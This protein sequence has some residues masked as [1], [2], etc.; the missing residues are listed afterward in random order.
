MLSRNLYIIDGN[1]TAEL[2]K[3]FEENV[4]LSGEVKKV[5][6]AA[7]HDDIVKKLPT[8]VAH[9]TLRQLVICVK[10]Y[11]HVEVLVVP[12]PYIHK[13]DLRDRW[14]G[15]MGK[16]EAIVSDANAVPVTTVEGRCFPEITRDGSGY[17]KQ[18]SDDEGRPTA[19]GARKMVSF[20]KEVMSVPMQ[21][22]E[23][24][25]KSFDKPPQERRN[26]ERTTNES[27]NVDRPVQ[28]RRDTEKPVQERRPLE[29]S[30]SARTTRA[31]SVLVV[32]SVDP[33]TS[34]R[35]I[36][37]PEQESEDN[38]AQEE[39]PLRSNY[40]RN[41]SRKRRRDEKADNNR[42]YDKRR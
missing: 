31:E 19:Q 14:E 20:L 23:V 32:N 16:F 29:K 39:R 12:P 11:P 3:N 30:E 17:D 40:R 25:R 24:D 10:R 2:A 22:Q 42:A 36:V 18:Y 26:F 37:P 33:T 5:V 41:Q 13:Q 38:P 7:G 6:I 8:E 4:F 1:S 15:Y 27:K 35:Q 28:N 34:R 21:L 9:S